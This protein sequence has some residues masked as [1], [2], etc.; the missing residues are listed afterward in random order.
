[1]AKELKPVKTKPEYYELLEKRIHEHL[2]REIFI[3]LL[4]EIGLTQKVLTNSLSDLADAIASG[5]VRYIDG[6]F[7][8]KLNS[9]ISIELRNIGARWDRNHGWF[10]LPPQDLPVDIRAAV[11]TAESRFQ[12]TLERVAKKLSS[13]SPSE[14]AERLDTNSLYAHTIF[15]AEKDFKDSTKSI[16]VDVKFTPEQRAQLIEKYADDMSRYIQNWTEDEIIKMRKWIIGG[17]TNGGRYES[18]IDSYEAIV[19]QIDKGNQHALS[20]A[21]FLARQE[22]NLFLSAYREMRYRDAG[23]NK[24]RWKTVIGSPDHPVR[25]THKALDGKIFTW[26]NPP[27]TDEKGSRNHPG[28]DFN[29]RCHAIPVVDF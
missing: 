25:D 10:T 12:A 16:A 4:R 11:G 6:H 9:T 17:A 22:T 28:Q 21:K 7:E 1:M 18:R 26:D 23:V 8:G 13:L 5:V 3:P 27:I 20:K 19:K 2:K 24:Y 14:I 15:S 29:C